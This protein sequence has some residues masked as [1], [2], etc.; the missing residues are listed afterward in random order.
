[1]S[2]ALNRQLERA[3]QL[4][5]QG[6]LTSALEEF[7]RI[8]QA[9]PSELS[10]RQRIAEIL[11]RQ[12]Q[13][14]GAVAEYTEVVKRYAEQGDFFKATALCRVILSL[15][16]THQLAQQQLATL[17]ASRGAAPA[18]APAAGK[19]PPLP[20]AKLQA[21]SFQLTAP[22]PHAADEPEEIAA[23]DLIAVPEPPLPPRDALPSIP[24]FSSLTTEAFVAVLNGALD[25]KHV[26]IGE[27]IVAEGAAGASMFAVVQGAVSVWRKAQRVAQ[28]GEGEFFGELALLTGAPRQATVKAD[29]EVVVLEFPREAMLRVMAAHP[30][31][32][33]GLEQF[34]RQR[35]Q[36]NASQPV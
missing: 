7:R 9:V 27:T 33:A 26:R 24:L 19:P 5:Q 35:Q 4:L 16:P 6:K 13:V 32:R 11:V 1:M 29:T 14:P 34:A 18:G 30:G 23:E 12:G 21:S 3:N 20:S 25:A 36:A 28:L 15:D 8:V 2:E 31:V 17:Y 22:L 10:A